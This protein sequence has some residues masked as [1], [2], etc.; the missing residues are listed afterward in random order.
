MIEIG[1]HTNGVPD[2]LYCDKLSTARA[3]SVAEYIHD[4]GISPERITYRG[5][6]KRQP[7]ATNNSVEGRRKNQRVEVKI[8]QL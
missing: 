6:G 1:G 7:I 3:K 8:L 4:K 5:Y 2:H